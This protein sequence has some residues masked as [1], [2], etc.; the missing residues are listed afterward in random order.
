MK[1]LKLRETKAIKMS[2]LK[3]SY[4]FAYLS[5]ILM[6]FKNAYLYKVKWRCGARAVKSFFLLNSQESHR[7]VTCEKLW[8]MRASIPLP[9]AC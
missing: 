2:D 8:R 7:F 1:V 5:L 4:I 3:Q 6:F 9:L